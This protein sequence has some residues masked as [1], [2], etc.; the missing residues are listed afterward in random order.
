[1]PAAVKPST[2]NLIKQL[3]KKKMKKGVTNLLSEDQLNSLLGSDDAFKTLII[4]QKRAL[5]AKLIEALHISVDQL[6]DLT[7]MKE[8]DTDTVRKTTGTLV[9]AMQLLTENPTS[10]SGR[11]GKE[12]EAE[13]EGDGLDGMS[14]EQLQAELEKQLNENDDFAEDFVG[15][16]KLKKKKSKKK[17]SK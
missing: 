7:R 3:S 12:D 5:V 1:M 15:P 9:N 2:G 17:K 4:T 16:K 14:D 6:I 11:Q 8:T 13:D 10:I